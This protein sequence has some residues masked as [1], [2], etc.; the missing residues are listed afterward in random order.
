MKEGRKEM[1][2][3]TDD[4]CVK[5]KKM[6]KEKIVYSFILFVS[7]ERK[8]NTDIEERGR[9]KD[10]KKKQQILLPTK[11]QHQNFNQT[12]E[13][14]SRDKRLFLTFQKLSH[15]RFLSILT[16]EFVSGMLIMKYE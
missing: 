4:Q 6:Q 14:R 16:K 1:C 11:Y 10:E 7:Q 15:P 12:S 9:I 13:C 5:R 3:L 2:V 8:K